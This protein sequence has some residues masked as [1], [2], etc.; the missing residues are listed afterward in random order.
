M[1]RNINKNDLNEDNHNN[2]IDNNNT[3]NTIN[4]NNNL[5]IQSQTQTQ[6]HHITELYQQHPD[7]EWMKPK[8][9]KNKIIFP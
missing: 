7:I 3:D 6:S 9:L 2:N 1:N 8:I 5:N 4:N